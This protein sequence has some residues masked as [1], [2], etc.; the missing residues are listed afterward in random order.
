M[1]SKTEKKDHITMQDSELDVKNLMSSELKSPSMI[2][3][4]DG[5]IKTL[6]D[7]NLIMLKKVHAILV[8]CNNLSKKQKIEF[9]EN[10]RFQMKLYLKKLMNKIDKS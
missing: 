7:D 2:N 3:L 5:E 1:V 4:A 10:E 6:C 9:C 8:N